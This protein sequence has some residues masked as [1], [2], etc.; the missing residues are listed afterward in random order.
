MEGEKN[1]LQRSEST[2]TKED[3]GVKEE[4]ERK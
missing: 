2:E 3:E 1:S 4:N